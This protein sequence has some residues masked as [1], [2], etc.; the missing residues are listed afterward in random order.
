MTK[1]KYVSI[2]LF[3]MLYNNGISIFLLISLFPMPTNRENL[4]YTK[5]CMNKILYVLFC[6]ENDAVLLC[7]IFN[8]SK[9]DKQIRKLSYFL[10]LNK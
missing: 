10:I 5:Y 8:I 7:I 6:R 3:L 9:I 4:L 2:K 1:G